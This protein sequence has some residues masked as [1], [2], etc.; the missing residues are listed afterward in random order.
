MKQ[1]LAGD[2]LSEQALE[3]LKTRM[4]LEVVPQ[5]L[6]KSKEVTTAGQAAKFELRDRVGTTD[7]FHRMQLMVGALI[8]LDGLLLGFDLLLELFTFS[9]QSTTGK[10]RSAK[11]RIMRT[12]KSGTSAC[13]AVH[14]RLS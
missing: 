13:V 9:A 11:S 2:V 12:M 7:S 4:D 8:R 10:R 14:H 1:N 3:L 5:Y 6:V